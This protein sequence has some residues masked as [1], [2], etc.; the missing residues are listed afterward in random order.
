MASYILLTIAAGAAANR[1]IARHARESFA[2]DR[3]AVR[4]SGDA[5][6]RLI[7]GPG[8]ARALADLLMGGDNVSAHHSHPVDTLVIALPDLGETW[9]LGRDS[10]VAD[11]FWFSSGD[12][13]GIPERGRHVRQFGNPA[14]TG[15]LA[16]HG[17]AQE[18]PSAA[19]PPR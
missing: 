4:I 1:V 13:P 11:E 7:E 5:A 8:E 10:D 9:V 15:W 6:A 2:R 19:P 17:F 14:L 12:V 18:R 16:S 3:E